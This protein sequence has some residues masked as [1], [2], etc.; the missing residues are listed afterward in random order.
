MP[1]KAVTIIG[2]RVSQD[3]LRQSI[4]VRSCSANR[5]MPDGVTRR[6]ES[7]LTDCQLEDSGIDYTLYG[8]DFLVCPFCVS[9]PYQ[10]DYNI[11]YTDDYKVNLTAG[12]ETV[13]LDVVR[14]RLEEPAEWFI[15]FKGGEADESKSTVFIEDD[16]NI[17]A[18]RNQ[19]K[20]LLESV[21][22]WREQGFGIHTVLVV[23]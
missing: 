10:I 2:C 1:T 9:Q 5:Y 23:R 7:D 12:S 14:S 18:Y 21:G 22:L 17:P 20:S 4:K 11:L 3:M 6:S 15:G 8:N 19:L 16:A 13:Q